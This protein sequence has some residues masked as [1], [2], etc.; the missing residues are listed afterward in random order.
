MKFGEDHVMWESA[1]ETH[2]KR[3]TVL[4]PHLEACVRHR[5][6]LIP[7]DLRGTGVFGVSCRNISFRKPFRGPLWATNESDCSIRALRRTGMFHKGF[8]AHV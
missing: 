4:I 5:S 6:V 2:M 7:Q 3:S 8:T 1:L